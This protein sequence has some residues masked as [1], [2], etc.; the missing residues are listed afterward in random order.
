M[1]GRGAT[2]RLRNAAVLVP[3]LGLL[4]LLPPLIAPFTVPARMFGIPLVVLYLFGL[5]AALIATACWLARRLGAPAAAS[6]ADG[7]EKARLRPEPP[8]A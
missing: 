1:S 8:V 6:G 5:W 7:D 3:L 4:L 2:P